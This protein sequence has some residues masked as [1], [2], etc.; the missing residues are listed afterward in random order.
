MS[1]WHCFDKIFSGN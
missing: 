1:R